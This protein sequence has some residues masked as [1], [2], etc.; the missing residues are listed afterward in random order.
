MDR[1]AC[2][3]TAALG[4]LFDQLGALVEA[5]VGQCAPGD[6]DREEL[7]R[8]VFTRVWRDA[9]CYGADDAP[10]LAWVERLVAEECSTAPS[11][12]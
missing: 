3:D 8:R 10:V 11:P 1:V 9:P 5:E 12:A 2:G 4:M 7:V 6:P